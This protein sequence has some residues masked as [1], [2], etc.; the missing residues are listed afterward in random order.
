MQDFQSN[1]DRNTVITQILFEGLVTRYVRVIPKDWRGLSCL[2]VELYGTSGM[3]RTRHISAN[4]LAISHSSRRLACLS[5][6][7]IQCFTCYVDTNDFY[8]TCL[9]IAC[10][11]CV[12]F[13]DCLV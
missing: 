3:C 8:H 10:G 6:D 5:V 2:R 13:R 11:E 9:L 4:A 12:Q 7:I 1:S